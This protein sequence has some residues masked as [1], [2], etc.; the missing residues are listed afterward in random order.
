V[1]AACLACAVL[2]GADLAAQDVSIQ[3]IDDAAREVVLAA[4]PR[5]IVSLVPVATEILF[6]LGEGSRIVGRDVG[7][8]IRP[9][10]E[11]VLQRRPDLVIVIGGS[12]NAQ[13]VRE[14]ELLE[15]PFIVVLFNTLEDLRS[16][17]L[18]LG[19]IVDREDE[20]QE[21]WAGIEMDLEQ[22][23]EAVAGTEPV[24]VYYDVGYPP[25]FTVGAGSY[26]D[27]LLS[28]AGGRNVFGD[29]EAPSPRVSLEAIVMRDPDVIIHP[30][31][32]TEEMA[33][34]RPEARPGWENLRA[35]RSGQVVTVPAE[36]VHRLGPRTGEA[37]KRLALA[38]H[39][40]VRETLRP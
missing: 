35:V 12:D 39:P 21:I 28:T 37:A 3:V 16:N 24:T 18:R 40:E 26:L 2:P 15:I 13:A 4:V 34:A 7:D 29:L 6:D 11:T 32:S 23:R 30:S 36:L 10:I 25:A 5:R 20:A 31:N 19:R 33:S 8:A 1:L 27:A 14:M 22:V 9:S 38:L 17:I